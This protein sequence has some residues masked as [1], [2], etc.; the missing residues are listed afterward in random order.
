MSR[1]T[2]CAFMVPHAEY[3]PAA[4][5]RSSNWAFEQAI[6]EDP[7][8]HPLDYPAGWYS[9]L[10]APGYLDCTDWQGPYANAFRAIRAVC[11]LYDVD[12][13]GNDRDYEDHSCD[14]CV[15]LMINGVYC[16]ETGCPNA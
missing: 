1:N 14:Q 15:A 5:E 7:T 8:V 4:S 16:H 9:R 2:E 13:R 12:V 6:E 11:D 10:S 3:L